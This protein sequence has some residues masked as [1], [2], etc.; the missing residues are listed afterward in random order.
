MEAVGQGKKLFIFK[1]LYLPP[2]NY[3]GKVVKTVALSDLQYV[4]K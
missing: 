1:Q 4:Q 2:D 3:N